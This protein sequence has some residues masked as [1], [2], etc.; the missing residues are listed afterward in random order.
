[1]GGLK[2]IKTNDKAEIKFKNGSVIRVVASNDNARSG[3]A[4]ILILDEFRMI[5]LTV[6]DTVLRKFQT[7]ERLMPFLD[8]PEYKENNTLSQ[9]K[10]FT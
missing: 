6:I 4:N 5:D 7:V 2:G 9:T 10:R 1:M 8:L 3:R